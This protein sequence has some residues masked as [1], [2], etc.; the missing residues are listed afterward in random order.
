MNIGAEIEFAGKNAVSAR[1]ARQKGHFAAL[2]RAA[3]VGVGRR[4]E[5]RLHAYFFYFCQPWHGIQ[6]AATDNANLRLSH[7]SSKK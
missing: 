1:V 3:D 6:T 2:E 7:P 4:A 5:R